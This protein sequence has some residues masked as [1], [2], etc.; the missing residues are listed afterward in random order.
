[1]AEISA[2]LTYIRSVEQLDAVKEKI[3]VYLK[4]PVTHLSIMD[5]DKHIET[6][7][8]GYQYA[9]DTVKTWKGKCSKVPVAGVVI[10]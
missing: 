9:R 7:G 3:D 6:H 4:P 1:M 5:W 2:Q 10:W 8:L